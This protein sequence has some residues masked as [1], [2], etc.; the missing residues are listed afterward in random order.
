[1]SDQGHDKS[2]WEKPAVVRRI[3]IGLLVVFAL[4][5]LGGVG[6]QVMHLTHPHFDVEKLPGFF[7]IYGFVAYFTIVT[8]A[9]GLRVLVMR[10]EDYYDE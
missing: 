8:V 4:S 3:K 1:M 5:V 6:A 9:K 2:W 10:D 7:A